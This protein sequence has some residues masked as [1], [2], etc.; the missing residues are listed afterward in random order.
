MA[1]LYPGYLPEESHIGYVT[2]GVHYSTWTAKE[3]T[4][5]HQRYFG[6][7][8]PETQSDFEVWERIY[9]VPDSEI[10]EI[11]QKLKI[12]LINYIK[13]RFSDNWIK[14]NENPKLITEALNKL[15]PN[16]LTIGFARR[17]ATYKRAH[18]L[19]KNLD[20]LNKIVNNLV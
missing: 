5:L 8:F 17:F 19:F 9:D 1:D 3:W 4:D 10:M 11:K 18:L 14:R 15:N 7:H 13:Q 20:R 16:A 6:H 2:N 12:S